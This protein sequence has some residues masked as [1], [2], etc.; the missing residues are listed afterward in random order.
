MVCPSRT[1]V[2][3]RMRPYP[4]EDG[5]FFLERVHVGSVGS[6][7]KFLLFVLVN[8]PEQIHNRWE[9][10]RNDQGPCQRNG[11]PSKQHRCHDHLDPNLSPNAWT[12][13]EDVILMDIHD[14]LAQPE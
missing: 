5:A 1:V 2:K 13:E 8:T 9:K 11:R 10:E 4:P 6:L 14:R 3:A 7:P 12:A